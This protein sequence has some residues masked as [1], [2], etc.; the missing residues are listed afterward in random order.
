MKIR[1]HIDNKTGKSRVILTKFI[2]D[3]LFAR[4]NPYLKF[5]IQSGKGS[6]AVSR[7]WPESAKDVEIKVKTQEKRKREE[8]ERKLQEARERQEKEL[9]R[10]KIEDTPALD[11]AEVEAIRKKMQEEEDAKRRLQEAEE[12]EEENEEEEDDEDNESAQDDD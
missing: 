3:Y 1:D 2:E 8:E 6:S 10:M 12:E 5:N 9:E 7:V 4:L 11:W